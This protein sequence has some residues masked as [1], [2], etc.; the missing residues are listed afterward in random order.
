[1]KLSKHKKD[2]KNNSDKYGDEVPLYRS[3]GVKRRVHPIIE[4]LNMTFMR[5]VLFFVLGTLGFALFAAVTTLLLYADL[6]I[7]LVFVT[8]VLTIVAVIG[9]RTLRKRLKLC[10]DVKKLCK[11]NRYRLTQ[12]RKLLRSFKW[13]TK[14]HDLVIQTGKYVYYVHYMTLRKYNATLVFENK[15]Q[16]SYTMLPLK[17]V[18]SLIFNL[19]PIKKTF[20]VDFPPLPDT[21]NK[22]AV[23]VILVNPVCGEMYEKDKD[24]G[25]MSTGNGM[26]KFGYTVYTGSGF[27]EAIERNERNT[28]EIKK[29]F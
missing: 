22:K 1:M 8:V 12:N 10:S 6:L 26:E 7:A 4:R 23:R 15:N 5:G 28:K 2:A 18:F 29:N 19:K 24:G 3:Y 27:V 11:R 25:L 14:E 17:N 13:N 16:I 21:D 9:T 20:E